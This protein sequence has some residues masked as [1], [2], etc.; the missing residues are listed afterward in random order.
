MA[1]RKSWEKYLL[2][3][4]RQMPAD[5]RSEF[6]DQADEIIRIL[7]AD[8]VIDFSHPYAVSDDPEEGETL[9]LKFH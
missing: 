5:V 2:F 1:C 4:V 6:I 3:V 9:P 8:G 7:V